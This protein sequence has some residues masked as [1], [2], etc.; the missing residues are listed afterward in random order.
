MTAKDLDGKIFYKI[1]KS[2][3]DIKELCSESHYL[4]YPEDEI[5]QDTGS[6]YICFVPPECII[7]CVHYG[8]QLT[9]IKFDSSDYRFKEIAKEEI[10]F[11]GLIWNEYNARKVI[12]GNN[13]SLAKPETIQ[14]IADMASLNNL[15]RCVIMDE[16]KDSYSISMHLKKLKF[17]ETLKC[18]ENIKVQLMNSIHMK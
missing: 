5:V 15:L 3:P 10:Q 7:L 2:T 6:H 8:N 1:S 14:M 4:C 16:N 13:Y 18:W 9:E 12:T 17:Y 11:G